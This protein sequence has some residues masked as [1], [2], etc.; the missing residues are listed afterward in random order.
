LGRKASNQ[1]LS[2]ASSQASENV[3]R[4]ESFSASEE[5]LDQLTKQVAKGGGIAF[6]GSIVGKIAG[7]GLSILFGQVLGP[8]VVRL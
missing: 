5:T 3:Q 8:G 6:T 1:Q 4:S 2:E 7:V